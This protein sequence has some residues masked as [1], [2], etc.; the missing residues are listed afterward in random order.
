MTG[1][2]EGQREGGSEDGC[3]LAHWPSGPQRCPN[4]GCQRST[5]VKLK[6]L[7]CDGKETSQ[8][9]RKIHNA[10][11]TFAGITGLVQDTH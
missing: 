7:Q 1:Q 10:G 8:W 4:D 11:R 2:E 6:W 3:E 5:Q 9:R